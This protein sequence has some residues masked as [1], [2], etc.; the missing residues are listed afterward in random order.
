MGHEGAREDDLLRPLADIDE[1]AEADDTV[2]ETADI[3]V[4]QGVD[5]GEGEKGEIEPAA[6]IEIELIGLV[7]HCR[8][9]GRGASVDAHSGGTV[10]RQRLELRGIDQRAGDDALEHAR[11]GE[12]RNALGR[13]VA[14]ADRVERG[15]APGRTLVRR[16][17]SGHRRRRA[18]GETKRPPSE[19]R[20][21]HIAAWSAGSATLSSGIPVR[22]CSMLPLTMPSSLDGS[23]LAWTSTSMVVA[24]EPGQSALTVM[25]CRPSSSAMQRTSWMTAAF[26]EE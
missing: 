20:N 14:D 1:A 23:P 6:I 11:M 18:P 2:A 21:T 26:D 9:A 22:H 7:D 5:L 8:V 16:S 13:L 17:K 15:D 24:V 19:A 12:A 25:P 4:A 10:D 3:D